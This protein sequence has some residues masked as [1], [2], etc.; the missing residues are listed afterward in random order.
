MRHIF[1]F[2]FFRRGRKLNRET[3]KKYH[4]GLANVKRNFF[5]AVV[6]TRDLS[7][8]ACTQCTY[9]PPTGWLTEV[10]DDS[11]RYRGCL[12]TSRTNILDITEPGNAIRGKYGRDGSL[13][14]SVFLVIF[15]SREITRGTIM[16]MKIK[17]NKI[18]S[19]SDWFVSFS[20][21]VFSYQFDETRDKDR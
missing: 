2:L 5:Q 6:Y 19:P 14:S 17:S 16:K 4:E 21:F 10:L 11:S 15:Y 12:F 8:E 13:C 7:T 18:S 20:V 1:F 3:S 9:L